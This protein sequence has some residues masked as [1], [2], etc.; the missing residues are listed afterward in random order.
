MRR[1]ALILGMAGLLAAGCAITYGRE[2]DTTKVS[3][4]QKGKTT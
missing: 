4:I 1:R 2:F 3:Q